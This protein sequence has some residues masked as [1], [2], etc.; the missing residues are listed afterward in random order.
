MVYAYATL[1][2]WR[3]RASR[4]RWN[5][6]PYADFFS[7]DDDDDDDESVANSKAGSDDRWKGAEVEIIEEECNDSEKWESLDERNNENKVNGDSAEK[8]KEKFD[9]VVSDEEEDSVTS[10]DQN[11]AEGTTKASCKSTFPYGKIASNGSVKG[12]S[13][14]SS[15]KPCAP[16]GLGQKPSRED[17]ERSLAD[18][19]MKGYRKYEVFTGE[20]SEKNTGFDTHPNMFI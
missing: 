17:E 6:Q 15:Q 12:R 8:K 10:A 20:Q 4:I 3:R 14:G 13:N 19:V 11:V 5:S 16:H 2:V 7:D 9:Q 1:S 18:M